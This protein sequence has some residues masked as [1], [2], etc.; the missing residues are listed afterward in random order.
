M[1]EGKQAGRAIA[2]DGDSTTKQGAGQFITQGL[3]VGQ[4]NRFD[5]PILPVFGET[6]EDIALQRDKGMEI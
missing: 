1:Q 2:H 3:N 5:L 4:E 6:T